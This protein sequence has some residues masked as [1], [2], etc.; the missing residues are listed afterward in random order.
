MG[1]GMCPPSKSIRAVTYIREVSGS[2]PD[3]NTDYP[4]RFM[5][6]SSLLPTEYRH[7]AL[8]QAMINS[9]HIFQ[10]HHSL[11]ILPFDAI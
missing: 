4:A 10:I 9:V 8:K 6:V 11:I 2:K 3:R 1:K 7:S 5:V